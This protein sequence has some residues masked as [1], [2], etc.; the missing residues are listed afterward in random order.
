MKR[1]SILLGV[2]AALVLGITAIVVDPFSG[3]DGPP[4]L[5]SPENPVPA[6]ADPAAEGSEA[7][8]DVKPGYDKLVARQQKASEKSGNQQP[9]SRF[10]PCNLVTKTQAES[11]IGK[12]LTDPVEA[13]LGPTCI[14]RSRDGKA[15]VTVLLREARF[16]SVERQL[17]KPERLRLSDHDA[18]CGSVGR[19]ML[20]VSVARSRVL[21][22]A[23]P[24]AVATKFAKTA[25]QR[26]NG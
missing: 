13:P 21:S 7:A 5:G 12:P 15:F 14:Y 8:K 11:I 16:T 26:L 25:V 23:A 4:P 20:H 6:R 19:P 17:D 2:A 9:R 22:V 24:C 18:V 10:T 1:I 3:D